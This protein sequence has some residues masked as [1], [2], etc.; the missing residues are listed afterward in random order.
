MCPT[1]F[2]KFLWH[3]KNFIVICF[4]LAKNKAQGGGYQRA[5]SFEMK[6]KSTIKHDITKFLECYGF[7]LTLNY[8]FWT[9]VEDVLQWTLEF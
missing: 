1:Q 4:Y 7:V 5:Q 8:E 6:W 3:P 2:F 9:L